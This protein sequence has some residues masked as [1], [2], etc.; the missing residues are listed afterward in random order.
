MTA[1][2]MNRHERRQR[3]VAMRAAV[4]S[5]DVAGWARALPRRG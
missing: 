2:E 5:S 4:R 3:M 1:V